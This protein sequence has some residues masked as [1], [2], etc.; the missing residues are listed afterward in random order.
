MRRIGVGAL[1]VAAGLGGGCASEV[2]IG[3]VISETGSVAPY[4]KQVRNGLELALEQLNAAGGFKGGAIELVYED[5]ATNPARG[6][7]VVEQLIHEHGV[8]VILGAVS[9]TVT[10]EIA[11]I[12]EEN[13]VV[14]LSPSSSAPQLSRAGSYF[15]R[16]YPSDI[17]EGTSMAMFA[18]ELGLQRVIVFAVDNAFGAGLA[19]VFTQQYESKFR[20]VVETF[21]FPALEP[22]GPGAEDAIAAAQARFREM[23]QRAGSLEPD[24]VY[25]AAYVNELTLLLQELHA[26]GIGA[27]RLGSSSVTRDLAQRAGAA[28]E[29]LV[30][31]QPSYFDP[32]STDRAVFEFVKAYRAKYGEEP[33]VYAAH[34]YDALKLILHAMNEMGSAHPDNVKIGLSAIQGFEGAAGSTSFD[35]NGDVV[36]YPRLF[37]I[38]EG[39]PILYQQFAESGG[40]LRES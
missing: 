32:A 37:I 24:G 13:R 30:Y 1:L 20:K 2:K 25:L 19:D 26:A 5:D 18:R 14:L 11:P 16:N 8:R 40:T 31:P 34:G 23:V 15:F 29:K 36:R 27:V 33:D 6:R 10:V 39:Q 22:A 12:C 38:H 7:Q 17:L 35:E 9:S 28:A 4:G 21:R 3:A